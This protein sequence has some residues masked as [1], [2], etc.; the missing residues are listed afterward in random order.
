MFARDRGNFV[1]EKYIIWRG[2][3]GEGIEEREE[4]ERRIE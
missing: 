4:G 3:E 1:E 2:R